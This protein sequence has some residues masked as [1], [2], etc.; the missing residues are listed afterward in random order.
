[1]GNS[2]IHKPETL[3]DMI[4]EAYLLKKYKCPFP[5]TLWKTLPLSTRIALLEAQKYKADELAEI[6]SEGKEKNNR[7]EV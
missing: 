5:P 2:V 7:E 6:I 3:I 1:M 4:R